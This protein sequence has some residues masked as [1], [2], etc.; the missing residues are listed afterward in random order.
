MGRYP[1]GPR[2]IDERRH[3]Y[4][5]VD[6]GLLGLVVAAGTGYEIEFA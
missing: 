1:N 6:E 3:N 2:L 5:P 4:N